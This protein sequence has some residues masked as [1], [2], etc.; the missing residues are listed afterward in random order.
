MLASLATLQRQVDKS[1]EQFLAH[2]PPLVQ[3]K[4]RGQIQFQNYLKYFAEAI[5]INYLH[6]AL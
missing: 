4:R 3:G 6:S 5:S 2:G 1:A